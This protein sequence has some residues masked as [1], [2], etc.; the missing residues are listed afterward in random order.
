MGISEGMGCAHAGLLKRADDVALYLITNPYHSDR[1]FGNK[2]IDLI[3]N[4]DVAQTE[5]DWAPIYVIVTH[6]PQV[7]LPRLHKSDNAFVLPT[8]GEGWGRPV[9]DAMAMSL[10]VIATNWSGPTEYMTEKNS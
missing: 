4:A 3:K 7:N 9:L 2:M 1:N 10:P 8:R 6:I 5:G